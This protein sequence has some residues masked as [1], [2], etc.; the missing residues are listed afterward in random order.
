[1]TFTK[2]YED[3]IA[4]LRDLGAA[5]GRANPAIAG[6][7]SKQASD[8]DVE[9]LLEGFAFLTGRLRQR[10]DE[11]LPE[12]SHG[13]LTLL[14]PH[15]LRPVPALSILEFIPAS[16]TV[17]TIPRGSVVAAAPVEGVSCRFRTCVDA[18]V[19][20]A[21]V[22]AV[23]LEERAYSATL[24]VQIAALGGAPVGLALTRRLRLFLHG[25]TDPRLG[26]RLL[27][28]LLTD[29]VRVEA[30]D[31]K[32]VVELPPSALTQAG[33]GLD[34]GVLPWPA[35][36]APGHQ[37]LQEYM[38]FP[39]RFLFVDLPPL[40]PLGPFAG[41]AL[42]LSFH[43]E[44]KP[45]LPA[46]LAPEHFRLNCTPIINL[47]ADESQAISPDPGRIEHR[48]VPA[49]RGG[50]HARVYAVESV[51]GHVQGQAERIIYHPFESLRHVLPGGAGTFYRTRMR[52]AVL[53]AG[54]DMWISFVNGMDRQTVPAAAVISVTL[55]CTNGAVAELIPVGGINRVASGSSASLAFR[56][57]TSV[58]AEIPPPLGGDT[59]W[60]LVSGLACGLRALGDVG[61]LRALLATY[62]FR[63][64]HDDPERH[65][66]SLMLDALREVKVEPTHVLIDGIPAHGR[67]FTLTVNERGFGG[68]EA[69][70]LFGSVL[71]AFLACNAEINAC[72]RLTVL[73]AETKMAFAWP[74]RGR[75]RPA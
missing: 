36:S 44:R 30:T 53:G 71:N 23:H 4:Y 24:V 39:A 7:L 75:Q 34:D 18:V 54:C 56:N 46:R 2:Y 45:D 16:G 62:D 1:M 63:A 9:R 61:V 67:H 17:S 43:M 19:V 35:N 38:T 68:I 41:N 27:R 51:Y 57:I 40:A 66:L 33:L 22:S 6:M 58:T 59:L 69:V 14:W 52:P 3:E 48:L 28:T 21:K 13:L 64:A 8:P 25:E 49:G 72:H 42:T 37:L 65:R 15:F 55:T 12:L 70:Y 5:F 60:R 50:G 74:A 10:L 31:G 11:E 26:M 73:G 29:V 20:P 47:Y 32:R